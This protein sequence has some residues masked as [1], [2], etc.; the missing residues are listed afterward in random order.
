[1]FEAETSEEDVDALLESCPVCDSDQVDFDGE[2]TWH[3]PD[4]GSDISQT[5][6]DILAGVEAD[7]G[8]P[9]Q[10]WDCF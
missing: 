2:E 5:G 7:C 3:C 8:E 10:P 1:M 9:L 6:V 4:C